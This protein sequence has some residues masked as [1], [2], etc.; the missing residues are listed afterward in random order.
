MINM[1]STTDAQKRAEKVQSEWLVPDYP[2]LKG[3][4][5]SAAV[6]G[7]IVY[8][9]KVV[10][11]Q[12]DEE[13]ENQTR[14]L[15]S[16][17]ILKEQRETKDG[18]KIVGF[19]KLRGNYSDENQA[20]S[21]ASKIVREQDSKYCIRVAHVGN[22]IPL[23]EDDAMARKNVQVN[24]EESAEEE[25]AKRKAMEDEEEK[26]KRIVREMKEREEEVKNA[27]DYNEDKESLNH[28]TMK[29]VVWLRLQETILLERKKLK[30]LEDKLCGVRSTLSELDQKHP[31]YS[32]SWVDNYNVERRKAG[33]PDH[34][35]SK[36]DMEEYARTGK[37][38]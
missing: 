13:I 30:D 25:A 24:V 35:P 18:K 29:M 21:K 9:P 28:Y 14:G 27:P 37:K 38:L 1:E 12:A 10:R 31:S 26:R 7:Q 34:V 5:G 15:V 4:V 33:I 3:D 22:W 16:F 17:M 19:F 2:P 23:V 11:S 32:E 8:Y 36:L 20:T 6:N